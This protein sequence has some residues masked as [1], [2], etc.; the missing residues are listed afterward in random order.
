VEA[1]DASVASWIRLADPPLRPLDA[2]SLSAFVSP[3]MSG[4]LAC[5]A[6]VQAART[7]TLSVSFLDVVPAADG[8][9]E[10]CCLG[11]WRAQS[12]GADLYEEDSELWSSG[13]RLLVRSRL[14]GRVATGSDQPAAQLV[15]PS[16]SV[17]R[18]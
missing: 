2:L 11:I 12:A 1:R 17:E 4:P 13:G 10:D 18:G 8:R 9:L 15:H 5:A 14:V 6:G 16:I 7:L 3:S